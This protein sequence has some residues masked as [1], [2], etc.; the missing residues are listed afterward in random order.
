MTTLQCIEALKGFSVIS[1]KDLNFK[2]SFQVAQNIS[3]LEG[4]VKP[5][6]EQ[7]NKFIQTLKSKSFDEDG[8]E[9]VSEEDAKRFQE[10]VQDLLDQEHKI[11][12]TTVSIPSDIDGVDADSIKGC[13]KFLRLS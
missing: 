10:D 11:K 12:L 6:E 8:N 9:K 13:I 3:K 7:R 1:K 5:F 4:V 2:S